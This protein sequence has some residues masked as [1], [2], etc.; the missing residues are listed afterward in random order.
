MLTAEQPLC[1]R[2]SY[3]P[4]FYRAVHVVLALCFHFCR[5]LARLLLE[6]AVLDV[7][8]HVVAGIMTAA[9][10]AH[11]MFAATTW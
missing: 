6:L 7:T 9:V 8:S 5:L 3:S 2:D 11:G 1:Q 4:L 10:T